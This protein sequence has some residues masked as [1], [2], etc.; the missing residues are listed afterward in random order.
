[1]DMTGDSPRRKRVR[2]D[3]EL[4]R[5]TEVVEKAE[6]ELDKKARVLASLLAK[7]EDLNNALEILVKEDAATSVIYLLQRR[8]ERLVIYIDSARDEMA[9][10][11]SAVTKAR[12]EFNKWG[13][14][15]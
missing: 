10:A 9:E 8:M 13:A 5:L 2:A 6:D 3:N 4:I 11:S 7:R 15:D 1:M 14:T 12:E